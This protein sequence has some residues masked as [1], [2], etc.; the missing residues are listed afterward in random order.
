MIKLRFR[1]SL[2]G[3]GSLVMCANLLSTSALAAC[4]VLTLHVRGTSMQ[5]AIADGATITV[6]GGEPACIEPLRHG[7]VVLLETPASGIPL[8]K[9]VR[10]LP[11]D[12]FAVRDGQLT[13][14]GDVAVNSTGAPYR[15]PAAR[16]KMLVLYER[17]YGGI[18]P[19][20]TYLVLG[21]TPSGTL[22][23]T[24]FG[25]VAR[26]QIVGKV[27]GRSAGNASQ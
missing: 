26:N 2:L 14:N 17:D 20:G 27:V 3:V 1:F 21:E 25:L 4:E 6:A 13:V 8:I 19:A 12:R 15:L 23:S 11:G 24:R 10:A 5:P 22:D 7:D 16:A 18:I 9:A